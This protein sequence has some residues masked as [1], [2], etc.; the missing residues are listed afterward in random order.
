MPL[1]Q[2]TPA[3]PAAARLLGR[4][5]DRPHGGKA[6]DRQ[7]AARDSR[8]AKAAGDGGQ[9]FLLSPTGIGARSHEGCSE[10]E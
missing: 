9:A 4:G 8:K 5:G 1:C 2:G 3:S 10:L 7:V 6:A